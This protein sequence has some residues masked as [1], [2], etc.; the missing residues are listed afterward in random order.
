MGEMS[1]PPDLRRWIDIRLA[2]G[3]YADEAD[4]FRDLVRRDQQGLLPDSPEEIAWLR[5]QIAE[6]EASGISDE[7]PETIIDNIIARRRARGG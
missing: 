1:F 2:D 5:E 6:G 4:Y 3:R 7:R